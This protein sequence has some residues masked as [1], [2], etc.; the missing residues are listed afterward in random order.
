MKQSTR[1]P[2]I[3][4]KGAKFIQVINCNDLYISQSG[5]IYNINTGKYLKPNAKNIIRTE[6]EYLSLPKLILQAFAG[7]RYRAGQMVY[8]D[9]NKANLTPQN[10]KY[11]RLFEPA[12]TS[13]VNKTDLMTVIR[14]YFE[15]E[16]RFKV[17][18]T[19]QTRLYL[20]MITANR[21]FLVLKS[22]RPNFQVYQ[23]YMEG[24]TNNLTTAA[25]Q[26]GLT[27]RDCSIIVNGFTNLLIDE[28]LDE[29]NS[30]Y[31]K[32]K[33]FKSKD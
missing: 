23:T 7:Q 18:D 8:I 1:P 30:G 14:C 27:V 16:K 32:V 5:T 12:R 2:A 4:L 11:V 17:K 13:E 15:V 19:F 31:L 25:N 20:Q 3:Q 9:G 10:L 29:L 6:R 26:H 33:N 21:L 28:I 22:D 24:L